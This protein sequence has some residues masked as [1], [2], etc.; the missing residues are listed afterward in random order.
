MKTKCQKCGDLK[1]VPLFRWLA[2]TMFFLTAFGFAF[3]LLYSS[4]SVLWPL[5]MMPFI[6]YDTGVATFALLIIPGYLAYAWVVG[7]LIK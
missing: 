6:D 2:G 3:Y 5:F 7:K 4:L 1:P